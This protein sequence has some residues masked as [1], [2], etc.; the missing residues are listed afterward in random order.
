MSRSLSIELRKLQRV[1]MEIPKQI[2]GKTLLLTESRTAE[3]I[4]RLS[5]LLLWNLVVKIVLGMLQLQVNQAHSL[6]RV[7]RMHNRFFQLHVL[8]HNFLLK[9]KKERIKFNYSRL[10]DSLYQKHSILIRFFS[11]SLDL[12][13]QDG[14]FLA[15]REYSV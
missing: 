6:N 12:F 5:A 14:A 13:N 8:C 3:G 2:T 10:C 7:V 1:I 9:S 4:F 15:R 11:Q